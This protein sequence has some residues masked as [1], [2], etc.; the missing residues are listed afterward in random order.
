[1]KICVF[2]NTQNENDAPHCISCNGNIFDHI[3]D[4]CGRQFRDGTFC[5]SCGVKVGQTAKI[6][7]ECNTRYYSNACPNCGYTRRKKQVQPQQVI[8]NHYT[9][10]QAAP[11]VTRTTAPARARSNTGCGTILLWIFL[12][13]IMLLVTIFKSNLKPFTKIIIVLLLLGL[14]GGGSKLN[15]GS[16]KKTS[17]N[18]SKYSVST[19]A[20]TSSSSGAKYTYSTPEPSVK[21][22]LSGRGVSESYGKEPEYINVIGYIVVADNARLETDSEFAK[23][24][25]LVDTYIPD[26]QFWEKSG[27][28]EH[29]TEVTVLEQFL[30]KKT[31]KHY[32]GYLRV[33]R[34]DTNE[35]CY[36][37]V[38]NFE[39]KKYWEYDIKEAFKT[40]Y[41][42]AEFKQVSDFY[43]V[44]SGK[45]KTPLDD[46]TLVLL[47]MNPY[48]SN[49]D[50]TNNPITGVVFKEWAKGF[51]GVNVFFNEE[52]LTIIY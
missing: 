31:G 4:N 20:R 29:K 16:D 5:P 27:T 2:C 12:F 43:P 36:I 13:P 35:E 33:R 17:S 50:R 48:V 21:S 28:I 8:H 18:S 9:T 46:G 40:G 26:K 39:T 32:D 52:D 37:D 38:D 7:P 10:V 15:S 47:P 45:T 25:W 44:T 42:I 41:M 11:T 23:R 51:G 30:T 1:M 6:C 14:I 3:C 34:N 24:P 22:F 19:T 49:P